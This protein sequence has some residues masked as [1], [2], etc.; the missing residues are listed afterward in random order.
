MVVA[1][2]SVLSCHWFRLLC[3]VLQARRSR[4]EPSR[5]PVFCACADWSHA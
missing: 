3:A 4:S 1:D 5:H 2:K